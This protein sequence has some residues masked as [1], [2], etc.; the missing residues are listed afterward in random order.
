VVQAGSC[1]GGSSQAAAYLIAALQRV[2]RV[3]DDL[4]TDPPLP[5]MSRLEAKVDGLKHGEQ[6]RRGLQ[7]IVGTG[8]A[9]NI[10]HVVADTTAQRAAH[11]PHPVGRDPYFQT[12]SPGGGKSR[13][14]HD[15]RSPSRNINL[16]VIA[17][18]I[19]SIVEYS[20]PETERNSVLLPD[21]SLSA[22]LPRI[23][24]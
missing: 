2:T 19:S 8:P 11:A 7:V 23:V 22:M 13:K 14:F 4:V 5:A 16:Y 3:P 24:A 10:F 6:I 20:V 9:K 12:V 18:S 1:L 17:W 15:I 21:K